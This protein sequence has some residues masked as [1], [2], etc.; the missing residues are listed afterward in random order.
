M[1]GLLLVLTEQQGERVA[2]AV[3]M[4]AAAAALGRPVAV[5][6]RG[7]ALG[8]ELGLL[9]EM[10]V[11]LFACQTAM[12][13]S[14]VTADALPAGVEPSGLVALLADRPGWQLLLA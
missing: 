6:L 8:A 1:S 14:G 11:P 2:A 10:E 12:A 13:K 4:V 7:A 5:L 9:R 3:E